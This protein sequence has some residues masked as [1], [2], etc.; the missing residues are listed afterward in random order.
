MAKVIVLGAS[1]K[2]DRYSFQAI[3]RLIA[4]GHEVV[5]VN[6]RGGEIQGLTVVPDMSSL[7]QGIDTVTLY[8]GP[9]LLK[10]VSSEILRINPRRVI[11]NPG[12]ESAEEET[13]FSARGIEVV[14]GCTLV[15]L[16]TGE[17]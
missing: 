12:S 11:F 7:S 5:P 6:P 13:L 14:K 15:M 1:P 10:V 4:A 9:A 3:T 17:F 8:V 2:P 16:A